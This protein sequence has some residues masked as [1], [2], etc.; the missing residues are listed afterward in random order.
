MTPPLQQAGEWFLRSGIQESSGGVARYYRADECRNLPLSTEI[1]G[2]SISALLELYQRT[3]Q[4]E[5]LNAAQRAGR[6]LAKA[7]DGT[8]KTMPFETNEPGVR[9]AYFFDLGIVARS[10]L[11]LSRVTGENWPAELASECG[12]SMREDFLATPGYHCIVELPGKVHVPQEVWW[13]RRPGAFHLKAALAWHELNFAEPYERQLEFSLA[14]WPALLS[15]E[16]EPERFMDR[17]HPLGYFLEGLLPV[18]NRPACAAAMCEAIALYARVLRDVAPRFARADAY[19][20]L[21]RV[22]L[23]AEAA[24]VLPLDSSQAQE[25]HDAIVALQDHSGDV[26]LRG[27]YAFGTRHGQATPFANP[28]STAFCMQAIAYWDEREAGV[29][30][31]NW[32]ELI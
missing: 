27:G 7:W 23:F 2:Y 32:R 5:Y 3:K 1:T 11:R 19:A 20:Q 6:Y 4:N 13:S 17:L 31:A 10:L 26:R 21:L 18:L 30:R 8:L 28:V 14:E 12:R 22:R 25:E 16:N 9:F 15:T 24:G 29:F